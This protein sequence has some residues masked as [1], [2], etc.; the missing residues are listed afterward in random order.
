[1]KSQAIGFDIP[2]IGSYEFSVSFDD[3]SGK[4]QTGSYKVNGIATKNKSTI[5]ARVDQAIRKGGQLSVHAWEN[6]AAGD[7][8]KLIS[9]QQINPSSMCL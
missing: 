9:W 6:L 8:V 1:M 3:D 2:A 5:V 4:R 7:A